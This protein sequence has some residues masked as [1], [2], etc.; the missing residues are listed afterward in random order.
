MST[1]GTH[2]HLVAEERRRRRRALSCLTDG[3]GGEGRS[4]PSS[5]ARTHDKDTKIE[6]SH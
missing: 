6:E 1:V 3:G 4:R 2:T 5:L